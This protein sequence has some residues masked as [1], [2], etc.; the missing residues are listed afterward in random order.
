M[1]ILLVCLFDELRSV[2][3]VTRDASNHP[4]RANELYLWGV[5]QDH[6]VMAK[7]VKGNFTGH[8]KFHPQMF[9]FILDIMFPRVDLECVSV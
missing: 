6:R 5:L 3:L 2:R 7:L 8:P 4:D 1:T 9:M